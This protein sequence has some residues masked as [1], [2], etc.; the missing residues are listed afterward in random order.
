MSAECQLDNIRRINFLRSELECSLRISDNG[1]FKS[2]GK[3]PLNILFRT[4]EAAQIQFS[5]IQS[6]PFSHIHYNFQYFKGP[7]TCAS[8]QQRSSR[9][10]NSRFT[11]SPTPNAPSPA[12]NDDL[13][14]GGREE[15]KKST[16]PLRIV[17][18]K[19]GGEEGGGGRKNEDS[20]TP[21]D[22]SISIP[23]AGPGSVIASSPASSIDSGVAS[24]GANDFLLFGPS[25]PT[26]FPS[27]ATI[28]RTKRHHVFNF[29]QT[30]GSLIEALALP[31]KKQPKTDAPT[32]A[33]Q[34]TAVTLQKPP[35]GKVIIIIIPPSPHLLKKKQNL[36]AE[37]D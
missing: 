20:I 1:C 11:V 26:T 14:E 13:K 4:G 35:A 28:P 15:G 25:P 18:I 27:W 9:Q 7:P 21:T 34:M 12:K 30:T 37:K 10:A 32:A 31:G 19:G 2:G 17:I 24:P 36:M 3:R 16:S 6:P 33:V 23:T 29:S 8:D 22:K 5:V